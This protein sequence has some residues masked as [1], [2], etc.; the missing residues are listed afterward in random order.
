MT[1]SFVYTF[2]YLIMFSTG[3]NEEEPLNKHSQGM[4]TLLEEADELRMNALKEILGILTPI[5]GV[6]YLASAK[7]IRLYLQQWGEK[8]EQEHNN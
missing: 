3:M 5:E 2:I 8:R 1:N 7:R 4:T 6:E